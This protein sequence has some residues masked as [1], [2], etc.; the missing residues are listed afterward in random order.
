MSDS[1]FGPLQ[2]MTTSQSRNSVIY[3]KD[4]NIM[5]K[6]FIKDNH[7][8]VLYCMQRGTGQRAAGMHPC[9]T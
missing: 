4:D 8:C 7:H 9:V 5:K 1:L 6:K 2:N 3:P